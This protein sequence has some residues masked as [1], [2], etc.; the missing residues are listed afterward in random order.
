MSESADRD[1]RRDSKISL[2]EPVVRPD[3]AGSGAITPMSLEE[4]RIHGVDVSETERKEKKP[5]PCIRRDVGG[6]RTAGL[7]ESLFG[8]TAVEVHRERFRRRPL[9]FSDTG[10]QTPAVETGSADRAVVGV[11]LPP[12]LPR[13]VEYRERAHHESGRRQ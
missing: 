5:Q 9:R 4:G 13:P 1:E 12:L 11:H 8:R 2:E 10:K 6:A 3:S 7:I